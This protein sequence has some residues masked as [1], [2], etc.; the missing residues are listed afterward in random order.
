VSAREDDERP[1]PAMMPRRRPAIPPAQ[2]ASARSHFHATKGIPRRGWPDAIVWPDTGALL[3]LGTSQYLLD[4][5]YQHFRGR[6]RLA[7]GV[8]R[9]I[10]RLSERS[11]APDAPDSEHDLVAAARKVV[12][13]FLLG[14]GLLPQVELSQQNTVEVAKV[15]EQLKALSDDSSRRHG[16]EAQII[17][18][19]TQ[20]ATLD[21]HRH[22]LLANDGGASIIADRYG[23]PTRHIADII[24]ELACANPDFSPQACL[25]S[26]NAA[27]KVSAP[28]YQVRPTGTRAFTCSGTPSGCSRCDKAET[29]T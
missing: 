7:K 23:I 1:T 14:D 15:T 11:S 8:A 13:A 4:K 21:R 29:S 2:R 19:A 10:R 27:M 26:F 20:A 24:A 6:A 5:F 16:G 12:Q 3:A 9:E 17:V 25:A 28:P 22:V 18:L